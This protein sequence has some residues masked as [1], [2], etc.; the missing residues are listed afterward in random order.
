[1]KN[2]YKLVSL[3]YVI[4]LTGDFGGKELFD[5]PAWLALLRRLYPM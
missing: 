5:Y 4:T 2:T 1:M 3:K